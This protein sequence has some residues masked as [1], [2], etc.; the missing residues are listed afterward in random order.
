[1]NRVQL[2]SLV[3]LHGFIPRDSVKLKKKLFSE[4]QEVAFYSHCLSFMNVSANS[5]LTQIFKSK[6]NAF[7]KMRHLSMKEL[8]F[9]VHG[10]QAR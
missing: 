4:G 6:L 1:M 9:L 8:L 7:L 10:Q 2:S 5:W 3:A